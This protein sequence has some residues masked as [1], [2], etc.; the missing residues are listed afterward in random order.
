MKNRE[1]WYL[2]GIPGAGKSAALARALADVTARTYDQPIP[3]LRYPGGVQLGRQRSR[4]AGTDALA[5]NIQPA[6]LDWLEACAY[7][8]VIGEGDRLGNAAFFAA[9]QRLGWN[10]RVALLD[11]PPEV[12]A[13]RR[14][15]RGSQQSEAWLK[16]R[17]TKI[18]NLRPFVDVVID[19]ALPLIEVA[20]QLR[21]EAAITQLRGNR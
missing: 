2:I 15:Q 19:G 16:G 5:M 4:F 1:L 11:T 7:W 12:A 9:V 14:L 13:E 20:A 6:V 10:L 17:L 18:A 8:L 21:A 3:Y